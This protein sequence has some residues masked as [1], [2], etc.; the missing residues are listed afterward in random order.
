MVWTGFFERG[1]SHSFDMRRLPSCEA[2]AAAMVTPRDVCRARGYLFVSAGAMPG[3]GG[4][5]PVAVLVPGMM[6]GWYFTTQNP[7]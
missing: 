6:G 4:L 3:T 5:I 7:P 1:P 2:S